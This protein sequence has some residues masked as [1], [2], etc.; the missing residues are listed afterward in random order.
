M[1]VGSKYLWSNRIIWLFMAIPFIAYCAVVYRY[2]INI[3]FYDDITQIVW[4]AN[5]II[6]VKLDSPWVTDVDRPDTLHAFFYPNAGHI[7]LFTR[8]F[9]LLQYQLGGANFRYSIMIANAGWI[10][11]C[12]LMLF[13]GRKSLNL[14]WLALLPVPFLMLALSHWEALDFTLPAWQMYFGAALCPI[15][16][17]L[18]ITHNRIGIALIC[19][20]GA[21]FT[22]GGSLA[23]FPV[24]GAYLLWRKRWL[25]LVLFAVFGGLMLWLFLHFNPPG[26][27]LKTTPDVTR[28]ASYVLAFMGNLLSTGTWDMSAYRTV[29]SITGAVLL[30]VFLWLFFTT[31]RQDFPKM[32]VAYVV[33]LGAMAAY[34]R[35]DQHTE[36]V[37][38]YSMF[39]I[40]AAAA[41][42]CLLM[43]KI[44]ERSA[45]LKGIVIA[46]S[47]VMAIAFWL[48]TYR[49]DLAPLNQNRNGRIDAMHTYLKT[50]DAGGLMWHSEWGAE[51][52]SEAKRIGIY[53]IEDASE[54]QP[55]PDPYQ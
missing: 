48:D 30:L 31:E 37:S 3:P 1:H 18:A 35:G 42:Y 19:L 28:I 16:M 54:L 14:S 13:Y 41:I 4:I 47:T 34:K 49:V 24:T 7:P 26:S 38:R 15:G 22:S 44:R 40:M 52:L 23:L 39:A 46:A 12:L 5:T 9:T 33:L 36:V 53:N 2:A 51:I 11:S 29:H 32:L 25:H 27:H 6:D 17:L 20:F 21:L 43:H 10:A 8:L 55:Y 50:G 45:T